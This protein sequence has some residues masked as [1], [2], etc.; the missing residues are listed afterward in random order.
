ML[1]SGTSSGVPRIGNN[2]GA[3]DPK[4]PKNRRSRVSVLVEA[5]EHKVIVDCGPDFRE[6]CLAAGL[7]RL[8]ALLLTHSHADHTHGIDDVRQWMHLRGA[9]LPVYAAAGTWKHL[10]DRFSYVFEGRELY[11]PSAEAVTIEGP[12]KIGPMRIIA[13]PQEHG[14]ITSWGFRFEAGGKV[15]CYST[16]VSALTEAAERCVAG[17]DLW[18]VDALRREPH[19]THSHLDQTLG[20][21]ADLAPRHAVLTHMDQSMDYAELAAALPAHVEPGYDMWAMELA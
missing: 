9:P 10:Y 8:D 19:P 20:W 2:W 6:Q 3:C 15:F 12:I 5:G 11:R 7:R 21:I 18:I 1:G 17:A 16:D 14:P 4:E 13:F